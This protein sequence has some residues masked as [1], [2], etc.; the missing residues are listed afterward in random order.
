MGSLITSNKE[1]ISRILRIIKEED[2]YFIDSRTTPETVAY[3]IAKKLK[4]KTA[5]RDIFL[6]KTENNSY[7]FTINQINWLI[8][9]AKQNGKAIA[10][11]HPHP[12]TFSAIKDSLKRIKSHGIEIV[13]VSK[14]LD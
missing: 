6:D 5:F 11:G 12:T 13:F 9:K 4:I 8:E 2:L 3:H 10:I 7:Q 1:I 14:L